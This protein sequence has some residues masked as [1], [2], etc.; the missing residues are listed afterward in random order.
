[1][2]YDFHFVAD[3]GGEALADLEDGDRNYTSNVGR[4]WA[5]AVEP[6]GEHTFGEIIDEHPLASDLLPF[7]ERGIAAIEADPA[8]FRQ[9]EPE[10]GW[11]DLEGALDVL[12]WLAERCRRWPKA[13]VLAHR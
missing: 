2:S 5:D 6:D 10:N 9:W 8:Y 1:M 4:I 3:V 12:E 11:V 13:K 7:L